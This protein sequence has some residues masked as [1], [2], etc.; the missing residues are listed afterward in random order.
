MRKREQVMESRETQKRRL[1]DTKGKDSETQTTQADQYW[2][3]LEER[4]DRKRG[5]REG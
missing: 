3:G 1:R 4:G 2:R 5:A